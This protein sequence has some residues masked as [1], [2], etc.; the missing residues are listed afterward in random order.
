MKELYEKITNTSIASNEISILSKL[1]QDHINL[2]FYSRIKQEHISL[3]SYS[4]MHVNLAAQLI[5]FSCD[6]C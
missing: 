1:K 5:Y 6:R 2:T 4:R 3:N